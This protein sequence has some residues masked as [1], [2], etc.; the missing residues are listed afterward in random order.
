TLF[1][2]YIVSNAFLF[3]PCTDL[4]I[5]Y[6]SARKTLCNKIFIPRTPGLSILFSGADNP[7]SPTL[8]RPVQ[9]LIHPLFQLVYCFGMLGI[10]RHADGKRGPGHGPLEC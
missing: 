9:G 4:C 10:Y 8:F 2:S 3:I 6:C 7:V 5:F 1:L